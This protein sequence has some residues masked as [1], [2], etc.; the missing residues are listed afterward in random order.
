MPPGVKAA[1]EWSWRLLLI[2]AGLFGL[3]LLVRSVSEIVVP[4]AIA[5]LLDGP[6]ASDRDAPALRDAARR[7]R[8]A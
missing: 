6:A 7:G 4:L 8:R 3:A 5:L 2:A 1:S